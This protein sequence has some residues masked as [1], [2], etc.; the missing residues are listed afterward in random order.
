MEI[1][2]IIKIILWIL[3]IA[4]VLLGVRAL[5]KNFGIL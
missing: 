5:L 1:E 3:F 2:N 4:I